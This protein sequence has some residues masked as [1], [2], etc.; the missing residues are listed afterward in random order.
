[1]SEHER[2]RSLLAAHCGGELE[3]DR[4]LEVEAHLKTCPDCAATL[5]DLETT[6]TLLRSTPKVEP[7]PLADNAYHGPGPG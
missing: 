3:P 6:L 7:P 1:M 4:R 5:A 2:I